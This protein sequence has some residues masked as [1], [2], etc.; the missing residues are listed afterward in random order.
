MRYITI[1]LLSTA[2]ATSALAQQQANTNH[3]GTG[4]TTFSEGSNLPAE[5]I[6]RDD[7][8][9]ITVYDSPELTR[10]V[11]VDSDGDIRLPM[12]QQ[13]I[14][15]AGLNP[16]ELEKVI[17]KILIQE[18]VLVNPIVTISIVEYRSR[19]IT[20]IGA[21]RS[22][23]TFQATGTVKLLDAISRAGGIA[24]HA[25]SDILVSR[26]QSSTSDKSISLTQRIPVRSLLNIEDPASN[27][28]LQGGE[29]IR[30]P[31]AGRIFVAGNVKHPGVFPITDGSESSV[32]KAL[33][34]SEGLDSFSGRTAY[35]YRIDDSNGS[36][37]EIP[38]A[39]KRILARKSPDMP[40][41][42]NDMLYVT[43]ATGQRASTKAIAMV[44]GFGLGAAYLMY[45][46]T[47]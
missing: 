37:S 24:E 31:E 23:T 35:I 25:G 5:K 34:L 9:G 13:H 15:A 44:T 16:E 42:A 14:K 1:L 30:V 21:V 26:P 28:E 8:I 41:Y 40:L 47:R 43:N 10:S 4:A 11:R 38:V 3:V 12:V 22:P 2:V 29:T 17:S 32:L 7:L 18:S 19:P 27:L 45:L 20:V 36:K 46:M 33:A 39:V 6:G